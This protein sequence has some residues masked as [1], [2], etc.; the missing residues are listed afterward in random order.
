MRSS[1]TMQRLAMQL[2]TLTTLHIQ[3]AG[4]EQPEKDG[5]IKER[6]KLFGVCQNTVSTAPVNYPDCVKRKRMVIAWQTK[7]VISK[8]FIHNSCFCHFPVHRDRAD[9]TECDVNYGSQNSK[10]EPSS[11]FLGPFL[12]PQP[13]LITRHKNFLPEMIGMQG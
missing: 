11:L 12:S 10:T 4:T 3:T 2:T 13:S 5:S 1:N 6:L 7:E 8:K 9:K